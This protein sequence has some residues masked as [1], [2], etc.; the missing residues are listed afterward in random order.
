LSNECDGST[1]ATASRR[2]DAGVEDVVI[3]PLVL[4]AL[5]AKY[6]Y[7]ATLSLLI[8][9]LDYAFP[10]LLQLARFPLF[11]V[12]II[13]DG[14]AALLKGVVRFLPVSGM[15]REA[16]RELVSRH[17]AWLRQKLSYKAFEEALHHAFEA[18]MAWVFRNCKS[19]TPRA[20]LL[21]LAGAVLWLPISFG[22]A[23]AMHAVLFAKVASWPAWMQL[24]HPLATVV[25]KS[26]LLVLPVY[27]A[28]WPQAKKH[29]FVQAAFR[30]YRYLTSLYLMQKTGYRFRQAERAVEKML[31]ALGRG[32]VSV[33]LDRLSQS[34]L[35]WLDAVTTRIGKV[36]RAAATGTVEGL[37]KVPLIGA[38]VLSYAA[39][40]DRVE[41]QHAERLSEKVS[42]FFG[43]WSEKFTA[44]YY[45]AKEREEA[46][47]SVAGA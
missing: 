41:Q 40:Y 47:K 32:A 39:H 31:D 7:R 42:N 3:L 30:F 46:A 17:W 4:I 21:V 37:S 33:G 15:K 18:G 34:L 19:L 35:A 26:K 28:A 11:T 12:R 38:I 5:A 9:I 44:E 22:V 29:S 43:R 27:P 8:H 23:T 10:I 20:A 2:Y 13:G 6:L 45:E 14:I 24:L 25:A 36:S 1:P 16:W